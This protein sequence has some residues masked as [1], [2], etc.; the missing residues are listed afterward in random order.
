MYWI[1]FFFIKKFIQD[2]K[3]Y[4]SSN[5]LVQNDKSIN[6][7]AC[8]ASI[9]WLKNYKYFTERYTVH[10]SKYLYSKI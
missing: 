3:K 10:L 6:D 5:V 4:D 1:N 7:K 2:L 8:N 9:F